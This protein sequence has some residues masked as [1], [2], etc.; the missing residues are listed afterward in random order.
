MKTT[1]LKQVVQQLS[2]KEATRGPSLL[3]GVCQVSQVETGRRHGCQEHDT[4][5]AAGSRFAETD[6]RAAGK[7][8]WD[9]HPRG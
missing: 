4:L 3:V 8:L 6:L 1:P 7:P 9:I 2:K 5:A